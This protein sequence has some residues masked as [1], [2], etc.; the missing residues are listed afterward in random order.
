MK[1]F[2]I[3]ALFLFSFWFTAECQ[4]PVGETTYRCSFCGK[5]FKSYATGTSHLCAVHN[6]FCNNSAPVQ[7]GPSPEELRKN[8]ETKDLKEAADD[9]NDKGLD[10]YKKRDWNCAIR[11]FI[12]ALDYDPE[13]D[14]ASYNLK[15]ARAETEKEAAE[16]RRVMTE[17]KAAEKVSSEDLKTKETIVN[18]VRN[19]SAHYKE[20]VQKLMDDVKMNVHLFKFKKKIHEGVVLGLFNTNE[21]NAITDKNKSV[22]SAFTDKSYK[23]GEYFATSN[24]LSAEELLRGIVDNSSLGEY[25]LN[26]EHGRKLIEQLEG[27]QFDRLIAHS[28]G[29]TVSE[30]LIRKGVISVNEL[31]IIGGDRSLINYFGLNELITSGKVKRIVVWVNPG[32]IIPYGT[33]AG[34]LAPTMAGHYTK[35]AQD[36]LLAKFSGESKGGDAGVEYRYLKGTQ[37]KGQDLK[38]GKDVFDAHGLEVYQYNMKQYFN[39]HK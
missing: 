14:D 35:T 6:Y 34:L 11:Y 28:N 2:L 9:A 30:A 33:T 20:Q 13:N 19:D 12:E 31:N 7:T 24:K 8:R 10:C 16:I 26:T 27:T 5:W 4:V 32:D 37:Y 25:T 17:Y 38:F 18:S 3:T 36:Y 23:P 39:T 15:K 22:V 29:A 21:V 1:A